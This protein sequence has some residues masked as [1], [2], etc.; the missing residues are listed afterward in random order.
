MHPIERAA[1]FHLKFER[2]HSFVNDN[3]RAGSRNLNQMYNDISVMI[4]VVVKE[5]IGSLNLY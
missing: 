1:L 3:G 4:Q 2:L 5:T